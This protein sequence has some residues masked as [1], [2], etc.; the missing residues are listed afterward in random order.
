MTIL[1]GEDNDTRAV[2]DL[3]HKLKVADL[4][5]SDLSQVSTPPI[6]TM[7]EVL[8]EIANTDIVIATRFHT[9]IGALM[10]DRPVIPLGYAGKFDE[11]MDEMGVAGQG[12]P[13]DSFDV[14]R[15]LA[16]MESAMASRVAIVEQSRRRLREYEHSLAEQYDEVISTTGLGSPGSGVR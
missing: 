3:V 8:S 4:S 15:L 14:D 7:T 13:V 1:I 12:Q 6:T 11:L 5:A 10:M 2:D 9:V 16:T